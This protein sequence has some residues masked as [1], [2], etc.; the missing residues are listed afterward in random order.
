MKTPRVYRSIYSDIP[1]NNTSLL[2]Q[3]AEEIAR[4]VD[5]LT[6]RIE[7]LECAREEGNNNE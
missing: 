5:E 7:K 3:W 6:E 1:L 4:Y 2:L